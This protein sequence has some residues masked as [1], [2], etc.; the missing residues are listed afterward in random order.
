[1]GTVRNQ[2]D[3][4]LY[5]EFVAKEYEAFHDW[6]FM[7]YGYA[8]LNETDGQNQN[9][10]EA[11]Y[12]QVAGGVPLAGL[13]VL[14]V[15]C[16]RGGGAAYVSRVFHPRSYTGVDFSPHLIRFCHKNHSIEGLQFLNAEAADLPFHSDTFDAVINIESSHSYQNEEKF[17]R[18]V[19]RVLKPEGYF[20]F[21]DFR[22]RSLVSDLLKRITDAGLRIIIE[23]DIT[24]NVLYALTLDSPMMIEVIRKHFPAALRPLF[25]TSAAVVGTPKHTLFSNRMLRYLQLVAKKEK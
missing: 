25:L 19:S 7:N 3:S 8:N 21:A 2:A 24:E 18:S 20:L 15:G 12:A 4:F 14:E 11:L 23:K 1:M 16:G 9:H 5:Y 17:L 10:S 22:R 6:V 13:N